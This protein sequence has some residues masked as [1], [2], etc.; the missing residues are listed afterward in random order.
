MSRKLQNIGYCGLVRP[1]WVFDTDM[2]VVTVRIPK[3]RLRMQGDF[4]LGL[5]NAASCCVLPS[6]PFIVRMRLA[7]HAGQEL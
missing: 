5:C 7:Q 2:G 6:L 3:A 4:P 1:Q